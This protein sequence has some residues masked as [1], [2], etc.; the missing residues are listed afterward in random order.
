MLDSD[1]SDDDSD[2]DIKITGVFHGNRISH[3]LF[4]KAGMEA[5]VEV[6]LFKSSKSKFPIFPY[7]EEKI[8][9]DEYGEFIR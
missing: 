9:Y 4:I 5:K 2:T 1:D 6:G 8:K 7:F 3:D